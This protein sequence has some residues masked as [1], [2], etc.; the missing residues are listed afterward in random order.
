ML[1]Q[2]NLK[3]KYV[4]VNG[5][6]LEL[7]DYFIFFA[8][9]MICRYSETLDGESV[10]KIIPRIGKKYSVRE[11]DFYLEKLFGNWL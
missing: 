3:H 1:N 4:L 6:E 11:K 5:E 7:S 10:S 2:K 8:L 9:K